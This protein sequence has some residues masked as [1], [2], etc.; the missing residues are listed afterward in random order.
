MEISSQ[1]H[2]LGGLSLLKNP[3]T[4]HVRA[5]VVCRENLHCFGEGEISFPA[6]SQIPNRTTRS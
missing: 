2:A 5:S 1:L 4:H 6:G 3:G